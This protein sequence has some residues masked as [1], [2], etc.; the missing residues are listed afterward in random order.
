MRADTHGGQLEPLVVRYLT[1][2]QQPLQFPLLEDRE[3]IQVAISMLITGLGA[4]RVDPKR[5]PCSS[6]VCRVASSNC[7]RLDLCPPHTD[8]VRQTVTA[9]TGEQV[10][11][12]EQPQSEIDLQN[13][14]KAME[15]E[16]DEGCDCEDGEYLDNQPG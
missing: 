9:L 8:I 3:W 5:P 15:Q 11:T 12:D 14:L 13:F 6:T 1:D 2:E 16:H 7:N 4:G 10:P